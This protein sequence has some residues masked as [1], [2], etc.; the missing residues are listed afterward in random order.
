MNSNTTVFVYV[1][2]SLSNGQ[3][4]VGITND[5][6]SR[7]DEHNRGE[8]RSTR[9]RGPWKL[10]YSEQCDGYPAARKR[11]RFFKSGPGREF[12]WKAGVTQ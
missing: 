7:L 5:L 4:Y 11:E 6:A 9:G 1:L 2:Q 12:L 8:N 3:H 10:I